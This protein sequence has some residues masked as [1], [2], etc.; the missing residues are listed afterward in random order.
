MEGN[1]V[2]LQPPISFGRGGGR[3]TESSPPS[4]YAFISSVATAAADGE[5]GSG[6]F[7]FRC[8]AGAG[9]SCLGDI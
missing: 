3:S 5:G 9:R 6:R 4:L 1:N 8:A 7:F 2:T